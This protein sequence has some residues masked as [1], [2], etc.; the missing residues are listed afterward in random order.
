MRQRRV[1]LGQARPRAPGSSRARAAHGCRRRRRC[2]EL[3]VL[4]DVALERAAARGSARPSPRAASARVASARE[5]SRRFA[6]TAGSTTRRSS[7][8][9]RRSTSARRS[10]MRRPH[11]ERRGRGRPPPRARACQPGP[12]RVRR[13][14]PSGRRG[15]CRPCAVLAVEA[16]DP[17]GGVDELLLAG[18]ERMA[19]RADLDVDRRDWWI[20]SRRHC[21]TRRR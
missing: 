18:E 15:R 5:L 13:R 19:R 7:S 10:S 21:R 14:R 6:I 17:T 16:L 9:Y 4:G 3:A 8:S 11:D 2:S 20:G 1:E 12:R